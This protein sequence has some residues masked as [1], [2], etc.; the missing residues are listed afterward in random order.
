MLSHSKI[1]TYL[2]CR[3]KYELAYVHNLMPINEA[4]ELTIGKNYHSEV[5]RILK[6]ESVGIDPMTRAFY[7]NIDRT[8]W[9]VIATEKTFTVGNLT[10]F[11]D[12]IIEIDGTQYIVEHKTTRSAIDD[13]YLHNLRLDNQILIY[14]LA[15]GIRNFIYTVCNRPTIRQKTNESPDE[16][17]VRCDEWFTEEHCRSFTF[18]RMQEEV[19]EKAVEIDR[20]AREI[21]SCDFFP[22]NPSA[23]KIMGCPFSEICLDHEPQLCAGFI[24][25][26][27]KPTIGF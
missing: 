19:D 24:K 26:E 15:T 8:G 11:I 14:S 12:A 13:K 23:C 21:D 6:G 9:K 27:I 2:Q 3:R 4:N 5:E 10:G 18:T 17:E 22:R 1:Q 25:K 16:F 7:R 20:L